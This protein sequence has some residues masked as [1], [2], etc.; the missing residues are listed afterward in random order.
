MK[1]NPNLKVPRSH[2]LL[3]GVEFT[4]TFFT[5]TPHVAQWDKEQQVQSDHRK[6]SLLLHPP[7][8]L[9][10]LQGGVSPTG[11]SS[12]KLSNGVLSVGW[13]S[14]RT[15]PVWVSFLERPVRGMHSQKIGAM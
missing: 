2:L 3:S 11:E 7:H 6:L 5:S 10:W 13:S 15:A 14:S 4:H 8:T 1:T 12:T 9:P